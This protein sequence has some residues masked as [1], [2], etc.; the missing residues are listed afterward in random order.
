MKILVLTPFGAIEPGGEENL[1][2]AARPG[3]EFSLESIEEV[4]PL[5]Y[6]TYR[7]NAMKSV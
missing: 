6:T 2:K 4:F 7:Y 3:T 1:K 5:P